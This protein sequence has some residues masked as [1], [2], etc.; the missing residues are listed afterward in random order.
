MKK[1]EETKR[2]RKQKK[3]N[4]EKKRKIF[5]ERAAMLHV[6]IHL[7]YP[8][9]TWSRS[10]NININKSFFI[11]SPLRLSTHWL[12]IRHRLRYT[13]KKSRHHSSL[14]MCVRSE[15]EDS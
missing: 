5:F 11:F 8:M 4:R 6:Y 12:D 14:E 7:G 2:K 1:R 15:Q 3:E 13:L 10:C 9:H